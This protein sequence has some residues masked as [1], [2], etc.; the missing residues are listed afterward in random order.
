[1]NSKK[2]IQRYFK[3]YRLDHEKINFLRETYLEYNSLVASI[4]EFLKVHDT[5]NQLKKMCQVAYGITLNETRYLGYGPTYKILEK[6][7]VAKA[8]RDQVDPIIREK[9]PIW[10][11]K[12][13]QRTKG[14]K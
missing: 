9:K 6:P 11:Y 5:E 7:D 2:E 3:A 4:K 13:E 14:L 1:M 10:N 12:E 8:I